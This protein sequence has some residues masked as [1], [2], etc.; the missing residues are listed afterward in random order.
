MMSV[1]IYVGVLLRISPIGDFLTQDWRG[2]LVKWFL[3]SY[4]M[5]ATCGCKF[6]ANFI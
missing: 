6:N 2:S 1:R 5:L 3:N 4:R